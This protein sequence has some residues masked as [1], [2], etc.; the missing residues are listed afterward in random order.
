M[1]NAKNYLIIAAICL[2]VIAVVERVDPL[3]KI[4]KGL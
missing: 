3:K 2:V 4:V 1:K